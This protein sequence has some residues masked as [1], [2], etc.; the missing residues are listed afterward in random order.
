[1]EV[2]YTAREAA[3]AI[4][5]PTRVVSDFLG[6]RYVRVPGASPHEL[7]AFEVVTVAA[8]RSFGLKPVDRPRFYIRMRAIH[9]PEGPF[10]VQLL[11]NGEPHVTVGE[12]IFVHRDFGGPD[13][14]FD[15]RPLLGR[16]RGVERQLRLL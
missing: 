15:A 8:A 3:G 16:L 5:C 11:A 7:T 6:M 4:G 1:M 10:V 14:L 9:P 12:T 13:R 2:T